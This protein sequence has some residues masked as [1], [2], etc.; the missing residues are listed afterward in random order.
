MN[1]KRKRPRNQRAGCK[2]CKPWKMNG[3]RTAA[4]VGEK[5]SDHARRQAATAS[6]RTIAL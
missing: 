1:H 4:Y 3:V 2:L 5:F 6:V